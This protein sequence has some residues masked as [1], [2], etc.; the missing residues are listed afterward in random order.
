MTYESQQEYGLAPI[1]DIRDQVD[2]ARDRITERHKRG[3]AAAPIDSA[4]A[5]GQITPNGTVL[6]PGSA[7][8]IR[9]GKKILP[10]PTG[11]FERTTN[12]CPEESDG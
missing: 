12:P 3:I 8:P 7:R 5:N 1:E 2:A 10:Q 11:D 6:L 9:I 4:I